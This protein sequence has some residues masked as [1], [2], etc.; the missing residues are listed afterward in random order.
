MD[1]TKRTQYHIAAADFFYTGDFSQMPQDLLFTIAN[2]FN[3]AILVFEKQLRENSADPSRIQHII[4]VY[5]EAAQVPIE[6]AS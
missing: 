5:Y 1:D 2:H 3:V 4:R 6:S